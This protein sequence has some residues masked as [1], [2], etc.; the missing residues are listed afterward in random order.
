MEAIL[1][2]KQGLSVNKIAD[3][4]KIAKSTASI[5]VHDIELT[6]PQT[7]ALRQQNPEITKK[8]SQANS[9]KNKAKR[10]IYQHQGREVAK[11]HE[12]L[13]A[14]GC[15]LYWGEGSKG[16]NTVE[17]CNGDLALHQFFMKFLFEYFNIDKS[18]FSIV[19][20]CYLDNN[21]TLDDI[22]NYWT[23][24][25]GLTNQ[26]LKKATVKT[27]SCSEKRL[28][29]GICKIKLGRTDIVQHIFGAIQEYSGVANP[30]WLSGY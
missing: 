11:K 28:P 13:H 8:A 15:M 25:L 23:T 30:E 20:N 26:N 9:D 3:Q 24:S 12:W 27:S 1:L 7:R 29:Y 6:E 14:A 21:L 4:L 2:R 22:H 18:E 5:W 19:I 17:L 10:E 16:K